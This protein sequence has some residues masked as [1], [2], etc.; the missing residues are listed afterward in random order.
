MCDHPAIVDD[1]HSGESMCSEC[2]LVVSPD[3]AFS[4][5]DVDTADT[6]SDPLVVTLQPTDLVA[7][8]PPEHVP[9]KAT[10]FMKRE[11]LLD[12]CAM[13]HLDANSSLLESALDIYNRLQ[14]INQT[15]LKLKRSRDYRLRNFE[16]YKVHLA[17]ALWE[18]L[19]RQGTPWRP[20]K[21]AQ[22]F[23]VPP[24]AILN[25]E[26]IFETSATYCKIQTIAET[27]CAHLDVPYKIV[28][29]VTNLISEIEPFCYGRTP[30]I[31]IAA[32]LLS[33]LKH[34]PE[35]YLFGRLPRR[36]VKGFDN[37]TLQKIFSPDNIGKHFN[38]SLRT[39]KIVMDSLPPYEIINDVIVFKKKKESN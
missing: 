4:V 14:H 12:V 36:S 16:K 7:V 21:I 33:V 26:K 1:H 13:L 15:S 38:V 8:I 10:D 22:A 35:N 17:F 25:V 27:E 11:F 29:L 32:A 3:Y 19:N 20:H 30:S 23:D 39:V 9:V 37:K 18:A 2:G 28:K 24:S 31:I 34:L 5:N 6:A